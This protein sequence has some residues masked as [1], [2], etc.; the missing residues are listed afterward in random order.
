MNKLCI[1][2]FWGIPYDILLPLIKEAGFDGF[3]SGEVNANS[4]EKLKS[5]KETVDGLG[6]IYE[7]SHSTIPGCTDIWTKGE[8]GD[9]YIDVLKNNIDNCHKL[10]I[11]MLVVHVQIDKG[12]ENFLEL[13]IKRL[14]SV[15]EYAAQ[16][17]IKLA[18]ENINSPEF[19]F[20]TLEHFDSSNVGFCYDCGH[21][22]CHT[23]GVRYLPKLGHRLFCTHIHD[24]DNVWDQ[25]WIPFD[26][27]IDFERIA[28]ELKVCGYKGNLS[29][30]LC[31]NDKYKSEMTEQEY[32]K[33][34]FDA[35]KRLQSKLKH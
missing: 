1:G 13:G 5:L 10:S 35:V 21:E 20:A 4:L 24:N 29:L 17:N 16:K 19:L 34:S 6:L 22:A 26:G 8:A 9:K 2:V 18:F 7:T 12:S 14:E 27:K 11:P 30:E 31:Y 28:E 25:H 23:P 3:F 33:K 15:V 32:I